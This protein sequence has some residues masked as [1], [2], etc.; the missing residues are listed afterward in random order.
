MRVGAGFDLDSDY[1]P[2]PPPPPSRVESDSP[3]PTLLDLHPDLLSRILSECNSVLDVARASMAARDFR[4]SL[5]EALRLRAAARGYESA[6]ERC[7]PRWRCLVALQREENLP[8]RAAA[9]REHSIFIDGDGRLSTCGEEGEWLGHG[10]YLA[11]LKTPTLLS[12]CFAAS[13]NGL[14]PLS[15]SSSSPCS[16]LARCG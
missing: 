13:A 11:Q 4:D 7:D 1:S 12:S 10:G 9:G 6:G 8:R 15:A 5:D 14:S 16:H 2:P 3:P